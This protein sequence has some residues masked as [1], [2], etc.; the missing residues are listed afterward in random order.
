MIKI[1][2]KIDLHIHPTYSSDGELE[3]LQVVGAC[4]ENRVNTFSITDHNSV[5]GTREAIE[6]AR[7]R[8]LDF[9]P[10]IEIDC[11]FNGVDLHVLGFGVDWQSRDFEELEKDISRKVMDSFSGMIDNL[12]RLGIKVDA[13]E[14]LNKAGEKLPTGELIAEVLLG[15]KKYE[16]PGLLPYQA[17]GARGDMPYLNF[18]HDFFSQ[19]KPAYVKIDYMEYKDVIELIMDNGGIPVIAHPGLNLKGKEEL[20][21]KLLD[22]GACGMEVFNNYHDERQM[23][24]FAHVVQQRNLLMTGGSDFHGKTKPLIR[25]GEYKRDERYM[26]YLQDSV[27]KLKRQVVTSVNLDSRE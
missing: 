24:Y 3:V 22:R 20:V 15:D 12:D 6:I 18:Y 2:D 9:I 23:D 4:V 1:M 17:G 13:G 16:C 10:G 25:I 7:E 27:L 14:V 8:A 5:R 19:G 26:E 21:E 11:V